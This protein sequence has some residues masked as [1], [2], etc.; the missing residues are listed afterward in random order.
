MPKNIVPFYGVG[1][2]T[3]EKVANKSDVLFWAD[4]KKMDLN[5][6]QRRALH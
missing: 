5:R 1:L 2:L 6:A 4:A 3:Y